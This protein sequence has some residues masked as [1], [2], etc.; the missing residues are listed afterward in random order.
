M[1]A[2]KKPVKRSQSRRPALTDSL[3]RAV[4]LNRFVRAKGVRFRRVGGRYMV[5]VKL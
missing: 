1:K 4:T 2:K 5:D 3:G